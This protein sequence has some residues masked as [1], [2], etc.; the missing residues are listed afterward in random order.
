MKLIAN[1]ILCDINEDDI[2]IITCH[3]HFLFILFDDPLI[4]K[5]DDLLHDG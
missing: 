1:N 4:I 5:I 2:K 3:D